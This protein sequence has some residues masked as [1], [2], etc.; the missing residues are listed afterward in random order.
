MQPNFATTR[1]S[2]VLQASGADS[3]SKHAALSQLLQDNWFPLYT[4][5]RR[6]GKSSEEAE[7][8]IQGFY[9]KLL[10]TNLLAT[11]EGASRGRFRNFLLICLKNFI[12][13]QWKKSSAIKRGGHQKIVSIDCQ[14]ADRRIA[15]EPVDRLTADR[16]FDRAWAL[17]MV[18][19]TLQRVRSDWK[20]AG[21]L[22]TFEIL[23]PHLLPESQV[24]TYTQTAQALE[25]TLATV[26]I[27]IHRLKGEF[28]RALCAEICETLGNEEFLED[29]INHLFSAICL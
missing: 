17:E 12:N 27:R 15:M 10:E 5:V 11:V 1:W 7:D 26:K 23:K 18:Q 22:E 16:A 4:F 2:L 19:R 3:P 29:E 6:S 9:T 25:L 21:K 28:R 24:P 14:E 8:L 20:A 13:D